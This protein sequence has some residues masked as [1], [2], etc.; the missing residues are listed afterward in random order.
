MRVSRGAGCARL[1]RSYTAWM[2][3]KLSEVL[4]VTIP[5]EALKLGPFRLSTYFSLFASGDLARL[6][7]Y[8]YN[9]RSFK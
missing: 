1:A 2:S 6:D 8:Y 5:L 3:G 9:T 7:V 4:L